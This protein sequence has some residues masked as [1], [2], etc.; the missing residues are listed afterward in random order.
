MQ[1][2]SI[3]PVTLLKY[4]SESDILGP[5]DYLSDIK[6]LVSLK[7]AMRVDYSL[8]NKIKIFPLFMSISPL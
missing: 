1:L 7:R 8:R 4:V 2:N 5:I 3:Q 6:N